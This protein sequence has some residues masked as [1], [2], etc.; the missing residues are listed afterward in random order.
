[1]VPLQMG[2]LGLEDAI[3]LIFVWVNIGS[4]LGAGDEEGWWGGVCL[5]SPDLVRVVG[6]LGLEKALDR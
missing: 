5:R 4:P 1:M 2:P 6:C 3:G